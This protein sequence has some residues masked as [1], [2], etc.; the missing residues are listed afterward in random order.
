[1]SDEYSKDPAVQAAT[2]ALNL[3]H[4]PIDIKSN[5][6]RMGLDEIRAL[7]AIEE[8]TARIDARKAAARKTTRNVGLW[9][10]IFGLAM[11]ALAFYAGVGDVPSGRLGRLLVGYILGGGASVV[12]IWLLIKG[13]L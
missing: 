11:L 5:L 1:M 7:A 13:S 3:G 4:L 12:G 9:I 2:R 8:A 10:L 6:M